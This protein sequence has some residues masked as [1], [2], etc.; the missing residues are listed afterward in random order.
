M[1]PSRDSTHASGKITASAWWTPGW[2]A[3]QASCAAAL[4]LIGGARARKIPN[5]TTGNKMA[6][7]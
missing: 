5:A 6:M 2:A 4:S 3:H 7:A 1:I